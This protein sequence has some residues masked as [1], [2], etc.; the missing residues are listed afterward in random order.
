MF[1]PPK[2]GLELESGDGDGRIDQMGPRSHPD[3]AQHS[4]DSFFLWSAS[5]APLCCS[6]RRRTR[7]V[8]YQRSNTWTKGRCFF[9]L[10]PSAHPGRGEVTTAICVARGLAKRFHAH[11]GVSL[12]FGK[13]ECLTYLER[14]EFL[15]YWDGLK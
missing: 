6:D 1:G 11:V 4:S 9:P 3:P 12:H 15:L 10:P 13:D 7:Q 14:I 8:Y 2:K 5:G